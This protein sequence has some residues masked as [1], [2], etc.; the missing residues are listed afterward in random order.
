[1]PLRD[2]TLEDA[3]RNANRKFVER[4]RKVVAELRKQGKDLN[5][6]C[7]AEMDAIWD[8]IKKKE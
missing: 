5:D 8:G 2:G 6:S 7:L 1:M 3:L 4:F